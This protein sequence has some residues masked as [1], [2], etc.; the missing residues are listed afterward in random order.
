MQQIAQQKMFH[1]G[2][3]NTG[4]VVIAADIDRHPLAYAEIAPA[5]SA[6]QQQQSVPLHA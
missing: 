6:A 1:A 2:I 3:Y 4:C 5:L